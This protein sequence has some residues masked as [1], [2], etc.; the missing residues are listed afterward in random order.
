MDI[1][2]DKIDEAVLALLRLTLHD[3]FRAWRSHVR[4][5]GSMTA[6][7]SALGNPH[8]TVISQVDSARKRVE[9]FDTLGRA[10]MAHREVSPCVLTIVRPCP[11]SL[12]SFAL[13]AWRRPASPARRHPH[14]RGTIYSF[15]NGG[16][17]GLQRD[18]PR[19]R[20]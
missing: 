14:R 9:R 4:P 8:T 19:V 3:G 15:L 6:P 2:N 20:T 1:D 5:D 12:C 7:A 13:S 16:P 10:K 18:Y 11:P 17:D